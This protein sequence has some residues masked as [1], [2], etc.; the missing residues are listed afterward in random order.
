MIKV[1]EGKRGEEGGDE[2]GK[3]GEERKKRERVRDKRVDEKGGGEKG[4]REGKKGEGST[5]LRINR[6]MMITVRRI[7]NLVMRGERISV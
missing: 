4:G 2:R 5:C 6:I 3:R 7:W 1:R